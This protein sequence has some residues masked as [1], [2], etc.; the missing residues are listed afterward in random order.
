VGSKH[1][2]KIS[3][4]LQISKHL[5]QPEMLNGSR[6]LHI[7]ESFNRNGDL[8]A[9]PPVLGDFWDRQ[10]KSSIFRQVSAKILPINLRNLF[11]I[12]RFCTEM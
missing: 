3:F 6:V 9:E 7:L 4:C 5:H 1:N 11:I 8:E 12:V 2:V 10:P